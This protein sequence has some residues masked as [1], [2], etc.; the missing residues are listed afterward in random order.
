MRRGTVAFDS[1]L[2]S[3]VLRSA[4]IDQTTISE[5]VRGED[6]MPL[7]NRLGLTPLEV[8]IPET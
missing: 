1:L 5:T 8:E 3:V 2:L 6:S 4:K 7:T